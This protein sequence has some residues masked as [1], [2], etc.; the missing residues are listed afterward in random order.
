MSYLSECSKI[1]VAGQ[2][3]GL[4]L[5][6]TAVT[7]KVMYLKE[8]K[9]VLL[10]RPLSAVPGLGRVA[11]F[12]RGLRRFPLTRVSVLGGTRQWKEDGHWSGPCAPADVG[13]SKASRWFPLWRLQP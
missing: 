2:W 3:K 6:V 8:S 12:P 1:T 11:A 7:S 13:R 10:C 5:H 9:Q 4:K